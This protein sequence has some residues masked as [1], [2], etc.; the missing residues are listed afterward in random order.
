MYIFKSDAGCFLPYRKG[1]CEMKRIL[2]CFVCLIMLISVIGCNTDNNS[3]A[4]SSGGYYAVGEYDEM[5]TPYLWLNTDESKFQFGV[6]AI[7]SYAEYG[8]YKV[9]NGTVI[10]VSQNTTFQFE[11]KDKN[12]LTL[13]DNGDNDY[14]KIPIGTQFVYSEDLK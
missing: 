7:V 10:A 13:I 1:E 12:T 8:T 2:C 14:F 4:L 3:A 6:G 9:V 5:L 11:I